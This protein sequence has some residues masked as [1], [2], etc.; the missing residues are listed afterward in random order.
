MP[1]NH[2]IY[3]SLANPL[4]LPQRLYR[5]VLAA[6]SPEDDSSLCH[7]LLPALAHLKNGF[8]PLK[9][10][11]SMGFLRTPLVLPSICL[12]LRSLSRSLD[13]SGLRP[14]PNFRIIL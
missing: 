14:T 2:E 12:G 11:H 10:F 5:I 8:K 4:T 3:A 13:G 6:R 1:A 7:L 9:V